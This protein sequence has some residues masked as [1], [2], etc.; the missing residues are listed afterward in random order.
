[1]WDYLP[2]SH[3]LGSSL[4]LEHPCPHFLLSAETRPLNH[5]KRLSEAVAPPGEPRFLEAG[6]FALMWVRGV[7]SGLYINRHV[8]AS[9]S[10][11]VGP[12][13]PPPPVPVPM[14]W[15]I[16]ERPGPQPLAA[17]PGLLGPLLALWESPL[18]PGLRLSLSSLWPLSAGCGPP[19]GGW[20]P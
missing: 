12:F 17:P 3:G 7:G 9:L 18:P 6:A 4:F 13:I 1:M 19:A 2:S 8:W 16:P 11:G 15:K 10:A 14:A 5:R 20:A